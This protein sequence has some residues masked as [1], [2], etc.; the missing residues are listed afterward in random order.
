MPSPR[1]RTITLVCPPHV[2]TGGPEAIHQLGRALL[3]LGHDARIL[4]I[5]SLG[6]LIPNEGR[7]VAPE[8]V[9]PMPPEYAHYGVPRA[10]N[11]ENEPEDLLI[12]PEIWP[13]IFRIGLRLKL[14]MWWLSID[15]GLENVARLGGL[16]VL[17]TLPC[18]HLCQSHY[19]MAYLARNGISGLPLFDYTSPDYV[20][21]AANPALGGQARD[22]RVLY[23][24]RG[25]AFGEWLKLI[26]PDI[27][28]LELQGFSPAEMTQLFLTSRL[29]VD[30]GHHP[31]KDRM[32][33][34]AAVLGCCVITGQR[35]AAENSFDIPIPAAYNFDDAQAM[36]EVDLLLTIRNVLKDYEHRTA[37]FGVY[38]QIIAGEPIMFLAQTAQIFGGRLVAA[39]EAAA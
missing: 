11:L 29:Y 13:D 22:A 9:D 21:Q 24:A 4:Y 33:R 3:D 18:T 26:A 37:D 30:F 6:D 1:Y 27:E 38:R 2:R 23:P 39:P 16:E 12:F 20:A 14:A 7:I 19:A 31:G 10:A 8:I 34:E 36:R 28:C 15:N 32:P 17:R 25:R 5:N 35:G